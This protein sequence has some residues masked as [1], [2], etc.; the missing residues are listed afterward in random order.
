MPS[1]LHYLHHKKANKRVERPAD[2]LNFGATVH[3]QIVTPHLF[4]SSQH[5]LQHHHKIVI[6]TKYRDIM[7]CRI[8]HELKKK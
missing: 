8:L 1:I 3:V 2:E 6:V 5:R 7:F 4:Q